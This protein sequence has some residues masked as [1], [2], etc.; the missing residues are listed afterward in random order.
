MVALSYAFKVPTVDNVVFVLS[1]FYITWFLENI[2]LIDHFRYIKIQLDSE[3]WG[4]QTKE[5][6]KHMHSVSFVC[7]L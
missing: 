3:A 1:C 2:L 5:I 4:T 6:D 7:V